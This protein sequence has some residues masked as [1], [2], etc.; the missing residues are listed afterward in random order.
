MPNLGHEQQLT[1]EVSNPLGR[2]LAQPKDDLCQTRQYM[3]TLIPTQK[4]QQNNDKR[5]LSA[6]GSFEST[7]WPQ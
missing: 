3:K 1:L 4:Q 7:F 6:H 2:V 5:T